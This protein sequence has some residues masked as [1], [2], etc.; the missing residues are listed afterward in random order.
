MLSTKSKKIST[1]QALAAI[2]FGWSEKT[3]MALRPEG[4]R[5]TPDG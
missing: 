2:N 5:P 1:A 3:A 4:F